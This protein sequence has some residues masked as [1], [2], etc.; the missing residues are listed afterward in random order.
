MRMS[1]TLTAA[2][3]AM[4]L[5]VPGVAALRA[6]SAAKEGI[7]VHGHW[8]IDVREPDGRLVTHREFENALV[9]TGGAILEKFLARALTPGAWEIFLEGI[10]DQPCDSNFTPVPCFIVEP[11][12]PNASSHTNLFVNLTVRSSP[13]QLSG[14]ATAG[15]AGR[16][17]HVSTLIHNCSRAVAPSACGYGSPSDAFTGTALPP[18]P[19]VPG[20]NGVSVAAGQ[21]IQ[22]TV[23]LTFS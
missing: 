7:V 10:P 21:I 15:R 2:L 23:T 22:V 18:D 6:Q 4:L 9:S 17:D 1:K 13:L 8:A 12:P 3:I 5:G 16:I 14:T 11:T 19:N 20:Q